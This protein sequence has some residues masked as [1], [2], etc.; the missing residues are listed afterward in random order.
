MSRL[1]ADYDLGRI[2]RRHLLQALGIA[3][4][5]RPAAAWA[6][7][8]CGGARAGTPQCDPTPAKLPF[9]STGWQTVLLDHFIVQVAD[10]Q[11]EAAY[12][13]AL[14]NWKIRSDDGKQ[15]LLDIGD[16]GG[17]LIKG[18]LVTPAPAPAGDPASAGQARG[19][20]AAG[21]GRG[22]GGGRAAARAQFTGFC[23]GI[24]PWNA[25]TV[26]AELKN[27]GLNP[28]ADHDPAAK[29]ESFHV[30]DPGGF[31]VQ[32]SNGSRKNRRQSPAN[33]KT[34]APAPF[35]STAW[36]TVWLDHISFQAA[37]YKATVA[38]YAALLGWKPGDD[39]GS[40]NQVQIGDVG[41][42]IIRGTNMSPVAVAA[43]EKAAADAAASGAAPSGRGGGGAPRTRNS[44]DHISFGIAPW[45]A[46]AV[47]AELDKRGLSAS[48]DTGGNGST[49]EAL[50]TAKY[51]SFHTNT[52]NGFNLQISAITKATRGT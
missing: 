52:P 29:F 22:G 24:E 8:S 28:I 21:G 26:E 48:I 45:D 40:Q 35:E 31:D 50:R 30:V 7:G 37:D 43:R 38:F 27:R 17:I 51:Q 12:Y 19:T 16:W 39:E 20:G 9:A 1:F 49:M 6:Q 10:Y 33:G 11:K 41:D 46:D 5:M 13:Q 18:G 3:A 36:K 15:A 42:A 23:W 14:M 44:I 4:V 34:S 2:S 32:I 25:K 47:K